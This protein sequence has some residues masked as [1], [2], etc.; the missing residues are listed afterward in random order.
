RSWRLLL[1]RRRHRRRNRG[2]LRGATRGRIEQRREERHKQ[3]KRESR[4]YKA[5]CRGNFQREIERCDS[6]D[7]WSTGTLGLLYLPFWG[8][9]TDAEGVTLF[10]FEKSC[11]LRAMPTR[12][13]ESI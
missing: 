7:C 6:C 8:M 9:K 1:R 4:G 2:Q 5:T 13:R 10:T 3:A 12:P 11:S